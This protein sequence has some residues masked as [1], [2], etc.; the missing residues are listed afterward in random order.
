MG[1]QGACPFQHGDEHSIEVKGGVERLACLVD[2]G[3]FA[4]PS[5]QDLLGCLALG[6]LLLCSLDQGT[7]LSG[8]G[9]S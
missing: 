7:Y 9:A 2:Q 1:V 5:L 8:Y 4:I 6:E 3:Q